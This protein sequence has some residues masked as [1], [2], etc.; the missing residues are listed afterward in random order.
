MGEHVL[1]TSLQVYLKLCS[2]AESCID[3]AYVQ[4]SSVRDCSGAWE[5]RG[6]EGVPSK[7]HKWLFD[8]LTTWHCSFGL[9][10]S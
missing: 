3:H 1:W 2:Q 8:G 4:F 7:M 9:A 6:G 5:G 10:D